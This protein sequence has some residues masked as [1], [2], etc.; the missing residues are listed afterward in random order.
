MTARLITILMTFLATVALLPASTPVDDAAIKK[1]LVGS[2]KGPD[3]WTF[4]LKED[5]VMVTTEN[6]PRR[7]EVPLDYM[8]E[9]WDVRDGEFHTF[10]E[11]KDG[12]AVKNNF[13]KILSLTETKF[14]IQH[15]Y[16]GQH[17]GTWTRST[18]SKDA[19]QGNQPGAENTK[20]PVSAEI[21][22]AQMLQKPILTPLAMSRLPMRTARKIFGRQRAT[23]RWPVL[24]QAGP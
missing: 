22:P 10:Y 20:Q 1:Q 8:T 13:F 5:G 19:A 2:W 14:V 21:L 17:T 23:V 7:P 6:P 12:Q 16:H 11:D 9:R 3:D 15:K 4:V 18:A 24:D